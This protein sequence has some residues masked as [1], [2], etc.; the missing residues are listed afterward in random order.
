MH[1]GVYW[2]SNNSMCTVNCIEII[3]LEM[4]IE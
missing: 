3:F 1:R 4:C 2:Y